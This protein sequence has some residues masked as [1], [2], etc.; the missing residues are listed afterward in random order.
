MKCEVCGSKRVRVKLENKKY[1]A[2][3]KECGCDIHIEPTALLN[4]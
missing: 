2:Y 4:K 3:C 1:I